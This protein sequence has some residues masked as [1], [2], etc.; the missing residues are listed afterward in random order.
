[1]AI[2]DQPERREGRREGGGG[3]AVMSGSH[4]EREELAADSD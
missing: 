1:M 3:G 2:G 4:G